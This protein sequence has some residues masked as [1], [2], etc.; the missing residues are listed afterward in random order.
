MV[1]FCMLLCGTGPLSSAI[2]CTPIWRLCCRLSTAYLSLGTL[3]LNKTSF[4]ESQTVTSEPQKEVTGVKGVAFFPN[5]SCNRALDF[6]VGIRFGLEKTAV[7]FPA[8]LIHV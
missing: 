7:Y 2:L 8:V 3:I 5:R 1:A 6:V 4:P